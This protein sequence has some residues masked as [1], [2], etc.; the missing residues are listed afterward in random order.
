MIPASMLGL[1]LK[2]P[3][4]AAAAFLLNAS[5]PLDVE[6]RQPVPTNAARGLST[7]KGINAYD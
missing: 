4:M 1:G 5:F 3:E 2:Q 7:N 6:R